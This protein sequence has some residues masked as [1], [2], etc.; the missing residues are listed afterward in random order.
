MDPAS[1]ITP[2]FW[3]FA[4][5]VHFVRSQAP[6]LSFSVF[7]QRTRFKIPGLRKPLFYKRFTKAG[8]ALSS[9]YRS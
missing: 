4:W 6:I 3:P 7:A 1:E 8:V 5:P 2:S 9:V